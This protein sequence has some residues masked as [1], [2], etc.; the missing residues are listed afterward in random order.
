HGDWEFLDELERRTAMRRLGPDRDNPVPAHMRLLRRRLL[1]CPGYAMLRLAGQPIL[2]GSVAFYGPDAA[3]RP[4]ALHPGFLRAFGLGLMGSSDE[5]LRLDHDAAVLEYVKLHHWF[6]T[7]SET[8]Y[9][10]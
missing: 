9:T 1:C 8:E 3:F 7:R 4:S 10:L 5:V 2:Q 6:L